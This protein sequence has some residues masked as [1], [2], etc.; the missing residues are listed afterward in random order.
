MTVIRFDNTKDPNVKNVYDELRDDPKKTEEK[1]VKEIKENARRPKDECLTID[2]GLRDLR[3]RQFIEDRV[4]NSGPPEEKSN[5]SST[6]LDL[7]VREV[8]ERHPG[9]AK[10]I[11]YIEAE[12]I[13]NQSTPTQSQEGSHKIRVGTDKWGNPIYEIEQ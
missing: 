10:I 8:L 11:K 4:E 3:L 13:K 2:K 9:G 5:T 12:E 7:E 1:P 6:Y